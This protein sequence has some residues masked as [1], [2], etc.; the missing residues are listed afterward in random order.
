MSVI[1]VVVIVW[2]IWSSVLPVVDYLASVEL[3]PVL[4]AG[5]QVMISMKDVLLAVS[6]LAITLILSRNLPGLLEIVLLDRLPL[7]RGG[8]YAISF[9]I[10]YLV[11]VVGVILT[12]AWIGFSWSSV[13]WLAAGLTV[14]LGFGLQ[15][16][17]AN[18]V[19]GLII[20]MER[21]VRVG[22]FVTV[23]GVIWT[24]HPDAV[25]SNDSQ[26]PR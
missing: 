25:E 18:L 24:C 20:L 13:Q 16:I 4:K 1:A 14:A 15:E 2:Q 8:R 6:W 10:R 19:S 23:N 5:Q 7:D 21:P 22:D 3:W 12:C 26:G 9:V 11:V 17:F